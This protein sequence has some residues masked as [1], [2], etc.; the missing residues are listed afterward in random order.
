M[1]A[2]ARTSADPIRV[3]A[4]AA[5]AG[6]LAALTCLLSGLPATFEAAVLIVQHLYP[7]SESHLA[8]ILARRTRLR[9]IQARSGDRLQPGTVYV[10]PP[11]WHLRIDSDGAVL[12]SQEDRVHFVRP[13]ADVLFESVAEQ[14]GSRATAVVLSGSGQ[15]GADG[16]CSVKRAGGTVIAQDKSTSEHFGMPGASIR[17]G[18]V[19]HILPLDEIAPCLVR[20]LN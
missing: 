2:W 11:N 4:I 5:S 19:D 8:E 9:V 10:A 6:G 16:V 13:S 14:Y 18:K 17:T 15:D 12:L 7:H 1:P 3:V 20:L